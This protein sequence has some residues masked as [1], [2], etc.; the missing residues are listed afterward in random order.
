MKEPWIVRRLD[1]D[2]GGQRLEVGTT[3][4]ANLL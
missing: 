4:Q 1:V 2:R 3:R